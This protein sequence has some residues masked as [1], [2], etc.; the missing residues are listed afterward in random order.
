[1]SVIATV[2]VGLIIIAGLI[3]YTYY[4]TSSEM[5]T[6]SQQ[7]SGLGQQ[8]LVQSQQISSLNQQV[9]VLQQKTVQVVTV[10]NTIE[11]VVTTTSVSTVTQVSTSTGFPT[12]DNVTVL[13]TQITGGK[14]SYAISAGSVSLSGSQSTQQSFRITPVFQGEAI[15]ISASIAAGFGGCNSGDGFTV[16][17]YLNGNV[18][19]KGNQICNGASVQI[20]YVL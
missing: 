9:S 11:T 12:P 18:V 20:N 5:S 13:F 10:Q 16:E 6:I 17:L 15:S 19:A 1:M 3:T 2:V 4:D 7:N 8:A 14:Y